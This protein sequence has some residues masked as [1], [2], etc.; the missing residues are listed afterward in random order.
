VEQKVKTAKKFE[1]LSLSL[2]PIIS[3]MTNFF[4]HQIHHH[5][6]FMML[7]IYAEK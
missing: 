6:H 2:Q 7:A 5:H 4:L 1:I 3:T